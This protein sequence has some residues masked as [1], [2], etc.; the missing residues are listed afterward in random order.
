MLNKK[1]ILELSKS[2]KNPIIKGVYFLIFKDKIVYVGYSK[3]ILKRVK[4]HNKDIKKIFNKISYVTYEDDE[5]MKNDEREYIAYIK[6]RYNK[7]DNP[8]VFYPTQTL[9]ART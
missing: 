2:I 8:D 6:P 4:A 5:Q 3:D 1:Q 7:R 9:L